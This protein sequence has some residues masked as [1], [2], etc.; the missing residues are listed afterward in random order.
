M[1]NVQMAPRSAMHNRSQL[2]LVEECACYACIKV[3]PVSDIKEW[4][5]NW[6]FRNKVEAPQ[7]EHTA[8]CPYCGIDAILPMNL[9]EDKDLVNLKKIQYYWLRRV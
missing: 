6:D 8:I 2:N 7:N 3:F 5:D 1:L 4:T 9:E